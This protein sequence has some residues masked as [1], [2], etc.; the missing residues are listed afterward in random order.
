FDKNAF[1]DNP[2]ERMNSNCT[3]LHTYPQLPRKPGSHLMNKPSLYSGDLDHQ[4]QS[5]H[6]CDQKCTQR[7]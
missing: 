3:H 5:D 7:K 6:K 2:T 1:E 4:S